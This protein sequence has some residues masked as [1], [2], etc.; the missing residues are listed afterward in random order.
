MNWKSNKYIG[1]IKI[2]EV[3]Y[4][5]CRHSVD[6]MKATLAGF[7]KCSG[8]NGPSESHLVKQRKK[9]NR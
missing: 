5:K 3:A 9:A 4:L 8:L 7:I 2:K 6:R 1:N